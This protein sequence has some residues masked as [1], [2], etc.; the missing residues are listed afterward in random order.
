VEQRSGRHALCL[1]ELFYQPPGPDLGESEQGEQREH[2]RRERLDI[3]DAGCTEHGECQGYDGQQIEV[4]VLVRDDA[5][6]CFSDPAGPSG[7]QGPFR[8]GR[9]DSTSPS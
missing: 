1:A 3:R 6:Q 4:E 7:H 2:N 9:V 8:P 5:D